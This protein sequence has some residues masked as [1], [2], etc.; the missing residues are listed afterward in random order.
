MKTEITYPEFDAEGNMVIVI[1]PSLGWLEGD[2]I[3]VE[4]I[5]GGISLTK[6]K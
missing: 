5:D 4:M 1:P 2:E 6:V 3:N